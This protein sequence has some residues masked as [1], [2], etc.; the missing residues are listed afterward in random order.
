MCRPPFAVAPRLLKQGSESMKRRH[1]SDHRGFSLLEV[2]VVVGL[3]G[4]IAAIAV[5]MFG[6]AIA[7]FRL[8]GDARSVSNATAVAKMRAA[9]NFSR[10]RLFVD[11]DS[12]EHHLESLDKTT[13]PP[14][15]TTEGG[16]TYLS[17]GVSFGY[18]VVTTAP[19]NTQGTIGQAPQCTDDDGTAID[20][21]AC[22]IFNSR[23]VPIDVSGASTGLDAVYLTDGTAVYGVTIA[24][25][26]MLRLWR[27]LPVST[28]SWA[29]Q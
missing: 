21:T 1:G 8:S 7:N 18:G 23:G 26:G 9:S 5:P 13:T 12:G 16:S 14:H 22:I 6:N 3:I 28:P 11:L 24:A 20:N 29:L 25:T 2:M 10:V 19:P 15:W 17:S 4:V 27:T